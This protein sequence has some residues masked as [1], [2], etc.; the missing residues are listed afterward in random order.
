[1]KKDSFK[2][3]NRVIDLHSTALASDLAEN[4]LINIWIAIETIVPSSIN[5]G[6]KVK[7]ICNALEPILL[8][9]YINRL[10]QNLIRDLLKW[11]RSNLTDILKEI[12]NYK[13]KKINQLVL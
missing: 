3:L 7:K 11:G 1:M 5:G 13:D 8:K 12:D 6:G 10:L 9:E 4:Q 2:K